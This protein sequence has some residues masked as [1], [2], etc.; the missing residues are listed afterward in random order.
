MKD[1]GKYPQVGVQSGPTES[2]MPIEVAGIIGGIARRVPDA[3]GRPADSMLAVY[4]DRMTYTC[5]FQNEVAS[6]HFD[7]KRSEIFFRGRNIKFMEV[8]PELVQ[9]LWDLAE[10]LAR[11]REGQRLLPAYR[12]TLAHLLADK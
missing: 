11:D 2:E 12:E 6:I 8:A 4:K 1:T 7:H 3:D 5:I 10:V 9:S